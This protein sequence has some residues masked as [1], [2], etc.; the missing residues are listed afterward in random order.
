MKTEQEVRESLLFLLRHY[1]NRAL[2]LPNSPEPG[3]IEKPFPQTPFTGPRSDSK[4]DLAVKMLL[5]RIDEDP[6]LAFHLIG[7]P[8]YSALLDAEAVRENIPLE[9][10]SLRRMG[11]R[12]A[13]R[14]HARIV[15]LT[16]ELQRLE[17]R[18]LELEAETE[19]RI[20]ER[21]AE[22]LSP[23]DPPPLET[24]PFTPQVLETPTIADPPTWGLLMPIDVMA[25]VQTT[26]LQTELQTSV[27]QITAEQTPRE[28]TLSPPTMP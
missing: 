23:L 22:L 9:E 19:R 2:I 20:R 12:N 1:P 21:Q 4:A 11:N 3:M 17:S 14:R 27:A 28:V 6:D 25:P 13:H 15:T 5:D 26:A 24:P 16:A 8:A 10:A 18:I 7:T